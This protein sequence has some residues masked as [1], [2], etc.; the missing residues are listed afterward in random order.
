MSNS[1]RHEDL[2]LQSMQPPGASASP[3]YHDP[4]TMLFLRL[5]IVSD[6]RRQSLAHAWDSRKPAFRVH[7]ALE[8]Y[9][10]HD[11]N[12]WLVARLVVAMTPIILAHRD[13]P[14]E[15][16]VS[17]VVVSMF[18]VEWLDRIR[19]DAEREQLVSETLQRYYR[20]YDRPRDKARKRKLRRQMRE[21]EDVTVPNEKD[22]GTETEDTPG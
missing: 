5:P 6:D 10:R 4:I 1:L 19:V 16:I 2:E 20:E 9:G 3:K 18:I 14:V 22:S 15:L 17:I 7:Q 8:W 21:S 11:Q 13:I 12:I